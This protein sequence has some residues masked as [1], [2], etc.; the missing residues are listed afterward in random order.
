M[1]IRFNTAR[2]LALN[3]WQSGH[4]YNRGHLKSAIPISAVREGAAAS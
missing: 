3:G 2:L 4:R 1:P